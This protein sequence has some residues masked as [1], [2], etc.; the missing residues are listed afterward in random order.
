M[1][2]TRRNA[3][4]LALVG[5]AVVAT[6]LGALVA[7]QAVNPPGAPADHFLAYK[8]K[9]TKGAA[10]FVPVKGVELGDDFATARFD[11]KAAV[12][13]GSTCERPTSGTMSTGRG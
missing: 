11:L 2:G 13:N 5:V 1:H 7:A 10:K 12:A 6:T 4:N 8:A 3:S 9:P